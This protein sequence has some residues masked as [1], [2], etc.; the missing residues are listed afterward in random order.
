VV[1]V[2]PEVRIPLESQTMMKLYQPALGKSLDSIADGE[3]ILV[4]GF[5]NVGN[6]SGYYLI[7]NLGV[8]YCDQEKAG[9]FKKVYANRFFPKSRMTKGVIDQ[10]SGPTNAYLRVY[11][12]SN[13][14]ALVMWFDEEPWQNR[15]CLEQANDAAHALGF[16]Q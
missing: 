9:M 15:P 11:D 1:S 10:I 12:E 7:T 4:Y 8:H 5:A 14:M 2:P 16:S 3:S 13:K 6:C